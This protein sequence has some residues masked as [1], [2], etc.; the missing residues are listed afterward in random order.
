MS[1]LENFKLPRFQES[2]QTRCAA[3]PIVAETT[4]IIPGL[5]T[6]VVAWLI[7]DVLIW[8]VHVAMR[9]ITYI[10]RVLHRPSDLV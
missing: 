6:T 1:L 4:G 3:S 7:K 8:S 2:A 5:E 9:V 10:D